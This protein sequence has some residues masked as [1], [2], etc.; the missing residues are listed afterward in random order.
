MEYSDQSTWCVCSVALAP[1]AVL[2][3]G[4]LLVLITVGG[5]Q[6]DRPPGRDDRGRR[7]QLGSVDVARS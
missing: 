6:C 1:P 2:T 5:F 7:P 3:E 4:L